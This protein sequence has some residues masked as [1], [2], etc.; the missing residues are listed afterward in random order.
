MEWNLTVLVVGIC[1][2]QFNFSDASRNH[3]NRTIHKAYR[4]NV[5]KNATA[6]YNQSSWK[7]DPLDF[8]L[9]ALRTVHIHEGAQ[10]ELIVSQTFNAL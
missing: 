1:S 8:K 6:T 2:I 3:G 7:Y 4:T 10:L 5:I 9:T